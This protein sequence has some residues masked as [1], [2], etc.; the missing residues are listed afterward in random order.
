MSKSA[1]LLAF[2]ICLMIAGV[3]WQGNNEYTCLKVDFK[4]TAHI[5]SI[6]SFKETTLNVRYN[7]QTC[8][9]SLVCILFATT[10]DE[11]WSASKLI[12]DDSA[13]SVKYH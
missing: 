6:W 7:V 11:D 1:A 3:D 13:Y 2:V 10:T 9:H 8:F 5:K 4:Q 12:T